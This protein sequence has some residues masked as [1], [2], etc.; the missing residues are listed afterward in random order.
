MQTLRA[1]IGDGG[2]S[3]LWEGYQHLLDEMDE[4]EGLANAEALLEAHARLIRAGADT[5]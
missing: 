5:Q 2:A 1:E 4:F 3:S